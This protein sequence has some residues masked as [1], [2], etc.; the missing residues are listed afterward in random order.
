MAIHLPGVAFDPS[1]W[2]IARIDWRS[3]MYR[4]LGQY[5]RP[6]LVCGVLVCLLAS[7]GL[8]S[9][10][11]RLKIFEPGQ[12]FDFDQAAQDLPLRAPTLW[13]A[14]SSGYSLQDAAT[15]RHPEGLPTGK[16]TRLPEGTEKV[17]VKY[18]PQRPYE[19]GAVGF[20]WISTVRYHVSGQELYITTSVPTTQA[21]SR[22]IKLGAERL[23][24]SSG[25]Q[26]YTSTTYLQQGN[27]ASSKTKINCVTFSQDGFI[28]TMS[29]PLPMT[30][31][32]TL[33]E[34]LT[35]DD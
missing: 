28:V 1:C 5:W 4:V 14:D 27:D 12:R 33:A 26:V 16:L 11:D 8:A 7:V 21:T 25:Q 19:E 18:F 31:L 10:A 22:P 17:E 13:P 34:T 6:Y 35:L 30:Q 24:L 9:A 15:I 23:A 3:G 32:T 2:A 29:S 20:V